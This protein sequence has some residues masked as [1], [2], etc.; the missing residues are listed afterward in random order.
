MTILITKLKRP[1]VNILKGKVIIF[2]TGL[3]KKLI[4]PKAKPT[5]SKICQEAVNSIPKRLD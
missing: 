1:K 5:R 4:N 2:K 3:I